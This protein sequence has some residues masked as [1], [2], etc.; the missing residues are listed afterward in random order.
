M[1]KETIDIENVYVVE[2][3]QLDLF[4]YS[5][6]NNLKDEFKIVSKSKELEFESI[7]RNTLLGKG[8]CVDFLKFIKT[9]DVDVI[10]TDILS[11]EEIGISIISQIKKHICE[12]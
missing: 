12:S 2:E 9:T 4:A 7:G 3:P 6:D 1:Y 8:N 11:C 10:I 5:D